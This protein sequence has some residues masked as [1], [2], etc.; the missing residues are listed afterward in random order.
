MS[1]G[2]AG[3]AESMLADLSVVVDLLRVPLIR[4]AGLAALD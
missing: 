3:L 4:C 1:S 2:A